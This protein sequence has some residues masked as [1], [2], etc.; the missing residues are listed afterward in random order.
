M[1]RKTSRSRLR[2]CATSMRVSMYCVP[3]SAMNSIVRTEPR[4]TTR[5]W[6]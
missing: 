3:S 6:L 1:V 4:S 2:R 5:T